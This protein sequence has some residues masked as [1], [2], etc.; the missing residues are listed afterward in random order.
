MPARVDNLRESTD[1]SVRLVALGHLADAAAAQSRLAK[2]SDDEA[3]HDFRV[4]LRRLR[5]WERAF[6]PY[7]RDD[8]G[9]KLRRRLRDLAHDTGASRDLEVH[10]AWLAEQRRSLGRRQ[11]VGLDWLV[12]QMERKKADADR[13]LEKDVD[14]RFTRLETKLARALESYREHIRLRKDGRAAPLPVF[15]EALAPR[16][17]T[18]ARDLERHLGHV[19]TE[20][21][22]RE[23]HEARIAAKRLRY[24]LEP[25]MKIIPG[26]ADLVDRLKG[27][28]DVL[29][30]LHDA[31]VFGA[32]I[33]KAAA[34][35]AALPNAASDGAAQPPMAMETPA[36]KAEPADS[37]AEGQA[38]TAPS[39][40]P[41][42]AVQAAP[43]AA[44]PGN[45]APTPALA[46]AVPQP[47]VDLAP[48]LSVI[49]ERLRARATA[50]FNQFSAE[51]LGSKAAGFFRDVDAVADR[52]AQSAREGQEI[53]RKYLLR[54]VPEQARDSRWVDIAQGYLPGSKLRE[55]IRRVSIHHGSGRKDV[56]YFRTVKLG[57]GVTRTEVEEETTEAIFLAMWPLTKRRRLRKRRYEVD[58][59]GL[60]WQIDEFRN[61]DLVLAEI[62]LDSEDDEVTFPDWLVP[63]VQ[64][65]V[66][67]EPEFLN[68]N[69]AR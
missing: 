15:A 52:I 59:D 17:R 47:N 29:G 48:G 46:P 21:D 61:R 53:E 22:V 27:L 35:A 26:A 10:L 20:R 13:V 16:V 57:E 58:V 24:L 56:H 44:A 30:D 55:R 60:T 6:R 66:T 14:G 69:L 9:K 43:P 11:R 2:Q 62:E 45:P 33:S 31:Q 41:A 40:T 50:A 63:A 23:G 42:A 68:V 18:A 5:S 3:L 19:R 25:V 65:E 8:V 32:E 34:D 64:R 39:N 49:M 37:S 7:L 1:R 54:F 51:W 38:D 12:T 67:G 4:A 36:T 28:Q